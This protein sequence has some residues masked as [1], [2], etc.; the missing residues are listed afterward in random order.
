M[1]KVFAYTRVSTV[2]QGEKGVSLQEQTDAISRY[3]RAHNLEIA[4]W[5]EERETAAKQGRPVFSRMLQLLKRGKAD[6]VIIHKIDRSARNLGDWADLNK[7]ID[8][9]VGVHFAHENLDL[10]TRGGRLTADIQAVVASDYIRNLREEAKKGI[11]GRL[12]QGYYPLRAPL[13]YLDQGAA[14]AKIPDPVSAPLIR[15]AFNLY[16]TGNYSLKPLLRELQ[17]KG[18]RNRNGGSL[19]LNGLSTILNNPFYTGLI[20]IRRT[21]ATYS[22]NHEPLISVQ[23]FDDVQRLLRGKTVRR[24]AH[25]RFPYSRLLRCGSCHYSLIGELKKGHVYYRCHNRPFKTP[26][27]CPLTSIREE[28]ID[29]T[30]LAVFAKLDLSEEEHAYFKAWLETQGH[31]QQELRAEQTQLCTMQL[32][33]L[34][35]RLNRLTDLLLEEKIDKDIFDEKRASL[36]RDEAEQKE[37]LK[38]L[39]ENTGQTVTSMKKFVELA[40]SPSLLFQMAS[41]PEKRELVKEMV[42]NLEVTRKNV[43][44]TL[45]IPFTAIAERDRNAR[46]RPYPGTCRTWEQL[47]RKIYKFFNNNPAAIN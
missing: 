42:S 38:A 16:R 34:R 45:K 46:C 47:L 5:F 18:L 20:R 3:A 14:K 10:N 27:I 1:G 21:G 31:A 19:S 36:L 29:E 15:E 6:G 25:H 43:S 37:R 26:A 32:S 44:V 12:K 4:E 30:L 33:Q 9:G 28:R 8:A 41:A 7:I 35:T 24:L 17:S 13:G 22:G 39:D 2:R 23:V 40:K 11:Y